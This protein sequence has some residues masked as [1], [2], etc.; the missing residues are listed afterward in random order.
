MSIKIMIASIYTVSASDLSYSAC[1][2]KNWERMVELLN[3][4]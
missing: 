1:I 4:P 3:G 2:R